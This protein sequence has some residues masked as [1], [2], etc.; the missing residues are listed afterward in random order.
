M[1]PGMS[2]LALTFDG[3]DLPD[4]VL[5]LV[6]VIELTP[7]TIAHP[8]PDGPVLDR[9][10][11]ARLRELNESKPLLIHGV[12]LSIGSAD[13]WNDSYLGLLDQCF[14]MFPN[15]TWHSEHLGFSRVDGTEL[16]T[17]LPVPYTQESLD[18]SVRRVEA[19]LARYG[20]P[21]LLEPV[22]NLLPA[23]PGDYSESAYLNRLAAASG[24][25]FVVDAYNLLCDARNHQ[26]DIARFLDEL[27]SNHVR[28]V[29]VAGGV[30]ISGVQL[31][32]HTAAPEPA[33][34]D[35][36]ATILRKTSSHRPVVTF[37]LLREGLEILGAELPDAVARVRRWLEEVHDV[38]SAIPAVA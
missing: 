30:A 22:V 21:F 13:E 35:I 23:P 6:D 5:D 29:H 12:S 27:D 11:S 36:A 20:R 28:E 26:R 17:M 2:P 10:L 37:E 19:I 9:K 33:T 32:V 25:G 16:C 31:D 1:R 14:A 34:L 8:G 24:A 7:E 4:A 38:P 15:I 3:F 18:L